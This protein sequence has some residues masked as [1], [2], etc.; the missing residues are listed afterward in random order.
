MRCK[1]LPN[2]RCLKYNLQPERINSIGD[3]Q[4]TSELEDLHDKITDLRLHRWRSRGVFASATLLGQ[5]CWT[6]TQGHVNNSGLVSS[7]HEDDLNV[8]STKSAS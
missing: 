2:A 1:Q 3:Q 5:L 6:G 8:M 4:G 7:K